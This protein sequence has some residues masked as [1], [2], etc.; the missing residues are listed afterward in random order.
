M[1]MNIFTNVLL[2]KGQL[3]Q[4]QGSVRIWHMCERVFGLVGVQKMS[5]FQSRNVSI[6]RYNDIVYSISS[7]INSTNSAIDIPSLKARVLSTEGYRGRTA[8]VS[9][10]FRNSVVLRLGQ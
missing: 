3:A 1:S 9:R 10:G 2:S 5:P 6:G 7:K 4:P 8:L